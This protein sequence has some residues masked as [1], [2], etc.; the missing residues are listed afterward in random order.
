MRRP[1]IWRT[2]TFRL[3]LVYGAVFAAGVVALLG[4]IYASA[5]V[6]LTH[7]MDE[8]VIGQARALQSVPAAALPEQMR[9]VE[10]QDVRNVNFYGLFS[11]DGAWIAGNV[12]RLPAD[13]PVNGVPRE[14]RG[15]GFQPGARA[16][17]ERLPSGDILFVGFDAKTLSGLRTIILASLIWSGALIII[18]GLSLGAALSLGPLRRI[19][20]VQAASLPILDGDVS[21]RLPT[22]NRRDEID[23]LAGIA[24]NMMDEVE[25]LLWA[26]KSV[27]DNVAHDLR[28]PLTRL[29]ALLYRVRQEAGEGDTH[30]VMLDQ[31][32][33][34]TD[35]LLGRFKA[36]QRI[37]E[38]DRRERRAGFADV[39]LQALVEEISDL[40]GPLAEDHGLTFSAETEAPCVIRADRELLFEALSNL[41]G[42]AVKFTPTGGA[43]RLKLVRL[44]EGPRLEII[45]NGPGVPESERDA[46]LQRFY[47]GQN[48]REAPGSGL[49]LS[50]VAAVARLHDFRLALDDASPGLRVVL[51][52]WPVAMSY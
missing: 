49:G 4:L 27:G 20:A 21:A 43:I 38:I 5:A 2:T 51:D 11:R 18:L 8:I 35:A 7:Q 10:T 48:G 30:L 39:R 16:L 52:C 12:R 3:A 19:R 45:D 33:G 24:N 6:F 9:Q 13:V 41:V 25:R 36:I 42:N 40:Y 15:P 46:V 22:S 14:L 1:E 44:N 29:R 26:V 50:I 17:A 37:S 28:T 34:E 47:R 31:A 32:L 23:M